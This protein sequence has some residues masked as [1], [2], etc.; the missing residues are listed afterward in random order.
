MAK[1]PKSFA[2]RLYF[3]TMD[4]MTAVSVDAEELSELNQVATIAVFS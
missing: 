2:D 3:T 4:R 1:V